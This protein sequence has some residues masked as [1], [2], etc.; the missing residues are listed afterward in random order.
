MPAPEALSLYRSLL[1][2][3]TFCTYRCALC[4]T[5]TRQ[6]LM[7]LLDGWVLQARSSP[8]ITSESA[9][10]LSNAKKAVF[11]VVVVLQRETTLHAQ[12]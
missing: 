4:Q 11:T 6:M 1:K 10:H 7:G 5:H 8:T 3:G 12:C 2:Y 9:H